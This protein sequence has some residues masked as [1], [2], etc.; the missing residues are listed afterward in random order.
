MALL[1]EYAATVSEGMLATT[2]GVL[3]ELAAHLAEWG[4][5]SISETADGDAPHAATGGPF[6]AWSVAELLRAHR[7]AAPSHRSRGVR[8][9]VVAEGPISL[10]R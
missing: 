7:H 10:S 9:A 5:G 4:L 8:G 6:Q 1:R 2:G 3:A